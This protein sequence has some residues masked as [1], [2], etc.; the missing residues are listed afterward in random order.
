ML[1]VQTPPKKSGAEVL[2][3]VAGCVIAS[4]ACAVAL[5]AWFSL[6]W[7]IAV[8]SWGVWW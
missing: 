5:P 2:A 6:L 7:R 8:L 4:L 3:N 1:P